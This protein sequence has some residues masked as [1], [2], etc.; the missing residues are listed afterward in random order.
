MP[1]VSVLIPTFNCGRFLGEALDSVLAQTYK[2]YEIVIVDDGST[3]DTKNVVDRYGSRV[4]YTYQ[5][6]GGLSS[7]RNV[8]IAKSNGE[9]IAYLDADDLWRQDKLEKQ[10]AFLDAHEECGMV[11][12]E[13]TVINDDDKVI[14]SRFNEETGRP[15]P[16]G[17]CMLDLLRRNH[18]QV[19]TVLERRSCLTV[20]GSFDEGLLVAQDYYHWIMMV[21][22]GWAI[23]Y[24]HEPLGI[25]RWRKGSL[26]SSKRALLEDYERIFGQLLL[27][28]SLDK[29]LGQKG[30]EIIRERRIT[31][32]REL[33]YIDRVEG[34]IKNALSR[35][36][37][38]IKESPFHVD[39]YVELLKSC[40]SM[41]VSSIRLNR[42]STK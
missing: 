25:Y 24:L 21:I 5:P 1:R 15:V 17:H 29:V 8:T 16:E 12:S 10:V 37:L 11:H 28:T 6:N 31:T 13:V 40:L 32:Q 18:I 23:G 7:A 22:H 36:V 35:I 19:P 9:L 38:L 33:T 4:I 30:R 39:T 2:D 14:Y 42:I 27:P 41:I 26:M 20:A 34:R 3:D